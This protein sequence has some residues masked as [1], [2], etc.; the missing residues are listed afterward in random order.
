MRRVAFAIVLAGVPLASGTPARASTGVSIDVGK[1][2]ISQKLLPGGAYRLPV[3]G[4]HNPAASERRTAS[5]S[6]ISRTRRHVDPKGMVPLH[7]GLAHARTRRDPRGEYPPRTSTGS[8]AGEVRSD[9]AAWWWRLAR[10][11][12]EH[13]PWMWI[14]PV[15]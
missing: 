8:G 12:M 13:A 1:I 7:A 5:P 10:F 2:A 14:L 6:P 3:F 9:L 4:V 11:F 15:A